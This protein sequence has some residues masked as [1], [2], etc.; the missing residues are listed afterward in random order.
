M[1]VTRAFVC[2]IGLLLAGAAGAFAA[3][4][5]LSTQEKADGWV[6]LFDG[7]TLD[8]WDTFDNAHWRAENGAITA[9]G[10]AP[11]NLFSKRTFADFVLRI[12]FRTPDA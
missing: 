3:E 2:A 1:I 4:N 8:G 9:S 6:L 11:G 7:T 10:E 12:D 5:S